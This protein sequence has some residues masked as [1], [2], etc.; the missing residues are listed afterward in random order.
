MPQLMTIRQ[1]A[2]ALQITPEL[3]RQRCN[4]KTFRDNKIARR[5]G[6]EW[7]VDY[8]KYRKIVWGDK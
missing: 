8:Q 2:D 7:R 6:R 5:E 4:S 1:F 3:A